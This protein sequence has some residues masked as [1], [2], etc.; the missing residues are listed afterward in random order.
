MCRHIFIKL[1]TKKFHKHAFGYSGTAAFVTS[2]K[3]CKPKVSWFGQCN[4][5]RLAIPFKAAKFRGHTPGLAPFPVS[6]YCP[7]AP[8]AIQ[9]VPPHPRL[10]V[11]I[12]N[13]AFIFCYDLRKQ[14]YDLLTRYCRPLYCT[15][16]F[17]SVS[18]RRAGEVA[19]ILQ[20]SAC[21]HLRLTL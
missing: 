4:N 9:L 7:P 12:I 19:Q 20:P 16:E 18:G 8:P 10:F 13:L 6:W 14:L 17:R 21:L 2:M 5:V 1:A 3:K 15:H 11:I